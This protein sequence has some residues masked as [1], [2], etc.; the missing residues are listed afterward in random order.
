MIKVGS[1]IQTDL[2]RYLL[3]ELIF[4]KISV[5]LLIIYNLQPAK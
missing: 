1:T 5:K 3:Y 4:V 2:Y